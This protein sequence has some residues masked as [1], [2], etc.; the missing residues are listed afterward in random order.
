MSDAVKEEAKRQLA[1]LKEGADEIIGEEELLERLSESLR[2]K[3]PLRVKLGMDPSAPDLHLGH[4]VVLGKLKRFQ[5]LGHTPIFLI[6]DFTAQIGDPTGKNKTR[7]PLSA[8]EVAKNAETYVQQVAQILDLD[9]VEIRFNAEWMNELSSV[10]MVRLC[11]TCTV[12]RLLERDDF[13]KRY[14]SGTPISVHE[15]LYPFVQGYDSFALE[16]DVELGGTDQKFN[17]LMGRDVQRAYGQR[18]QIAMTHPLLV[19]TDGSEKMSKSLGN[20]I[21]IQDS[22][23]DMYG[24]TMRISDE[25]MLTYFDIL[26]DD[27]WSE[28]DEARAAMGAGTGDPMAFKQALAKAIVARF[29]GE[30]AADAAAGHFRQVVQDKQLPDE[31][32]EASVSL[33]GE[34]SASLLDVLLEVGLVA[35]KGEARRLIKGG[36]VY[37]DG[38]KVSDATFSL[39]SGDYLL[40]AGKRKFCQVTLG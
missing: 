28:L 7:P 30:E 35:S 25:L 5:E 34:P 21:E 12:A 22:P 1:L 40:R 31:I 14:A 16:A 13:S 19:G 20:T 15:F 38:D 23:E 2:D 4:T 8:D 9:Q 17:L 36:A 10:E 33:K 27:R 32:P 11:S 29:C 39:E 18:A 24:K 26:R 3:R 37:V 6:G